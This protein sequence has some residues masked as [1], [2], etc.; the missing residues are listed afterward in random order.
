MGHVYS[1]CPATRGSDHP[2]KQG[3]QK[4]DIGESNKESL[5]DGHGPCDLGKTFHLE[6]E[7][8]SSD[9]STD[10][11]KGSQDDP[12]DDDKFYALEGMYSV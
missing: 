2:P 11:N 5:D 12:T 6:Q 7:E 3:T 4:C 9:S 8:L 1:Q 10:G